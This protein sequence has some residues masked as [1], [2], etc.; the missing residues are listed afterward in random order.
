[1]MVAVVEVAPDVVTA[2]LAVEFPA[3]TL[4]LAGTVAEELLLFKATEIPPLGAGALKITVPVD[5]FPQGTLAG[6]S[7]TADNTAVAMLGVML[8]G[9]V[10]YAP[11]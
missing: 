11:L 2:K 6:F 10:T 9:A 1:M 8:S 4:T 5:E 3:I 7:D